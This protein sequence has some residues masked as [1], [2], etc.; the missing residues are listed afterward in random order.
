MD[1]LWQGSPYQLDADRRATQESQGI[2]YLL[3]YWMLRYYTEVAPPA[4][5]PFPYFPGP[6]FK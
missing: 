5:E 6:Y 1:F 2:D 4:S 3:P